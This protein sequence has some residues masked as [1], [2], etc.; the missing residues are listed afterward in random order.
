MNK[1]VIDGDNIILF[2]FHIRK[3]KDYR[4][5]I[6]EE[7]I[8][9]RT[10]VKPDLVLIASSQYV[11]QDHQVVQKEGLRAFKNTSLLGYDL[12]WNHITFSA[13]AFIRIDYDDIDCKW[14][15]LKE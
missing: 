10:A 15:C 7:L 14:S 13:Q 1:I 9:I 4:L 6:L 3:L 5:F 12:P 2:D 8:I 11:H